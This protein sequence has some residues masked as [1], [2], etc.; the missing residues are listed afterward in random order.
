MDS[1]SPPCSP[2]IPILIDGLAALLFFDAIFNNSPTP[3][4]SND[5]NGS[6]G[7]IPFSK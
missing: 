1:G 3:Y 5:R 6:T 2:Q 4:K 7:N